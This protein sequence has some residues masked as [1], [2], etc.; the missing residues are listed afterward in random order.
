MKII[1]HLS[2]RNYLYLAV[3]W[4]VLIAVL[5]LVSLNSI[6][7][8]INI[9]SNDKFF[10]F[11]FYAIL[12][13]LLL[14]Y[15]RK[16]KYNLLIILFVIIYGIIIEILQALLTT[17]READIYDAIANSLGAI[18]GLVLLRIVKNKKNNK[19]F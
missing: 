1:K 4:A 18:T 17:N 19:N 8:E 6:S 11:V 15:K 3:I 9:S 10:H 13:V 16:T 2:E 14:L 7:K 12:T 5:S